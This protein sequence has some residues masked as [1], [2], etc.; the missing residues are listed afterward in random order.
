MFFH[1]AAVTPPL[2]FENLTGERYEVN[3]MGNYNVLVAS[4]KNNVKRVILASSY[5]I[6]R[7]IGESTNESNSLVG[8]FSST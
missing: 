8:L 2:E 6:Y 5:L 1:L 4:A 7:D 3:V